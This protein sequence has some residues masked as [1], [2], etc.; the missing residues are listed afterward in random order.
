M[1]FKVAPE[2]LQL[3]RDMTAAGEL[4]HLVAERIWR[5]FELALL[6]EAPQVFISTLR[7]CGALRVILP[8]VDNLFG[9]PQPPEH[10]PE[11]DTGI[12]TLLCLEQAVRLST[13][14][15]VRYAVLVHDVGKGVTRREDWPRH[16]GHETLGLPLL[17]AIARRLRVPREHADIA[18][19]V[20]EHHTKMHRIAHLRPATL[21]SLLEALD[22]FRR[23]QRVEQ[24]LLACEAD[25]RGRTGFEQ[26]D[27]PQGALLRKTQAAANGVNVGE[28]LAQ[29]SHAPKDIGAFARRARIAAI[30]SVLEPV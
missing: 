14:P 11:V 25:A 23:P 29:R 12:H 7:E 28:L 6:S 5:E 9:V 26:R 22:A 30:K 16:Y 8:E 18:R 24:F 27:Y 19:L 20:C 10:H 4:Q 2:T 1:G 17:D 15:V 13:D 21:L 3:M